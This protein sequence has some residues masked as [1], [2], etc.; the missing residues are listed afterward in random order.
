MF[1][2]LCAILPHGV[3]ASPTHDSS[4]PRRLH[5]E[6]KTGTAGRRGDAELDLECPCTGPAMG[7]CHGLSGSFWM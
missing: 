5:G 3:L 2:C 6:A 4:A 1:F 7:T